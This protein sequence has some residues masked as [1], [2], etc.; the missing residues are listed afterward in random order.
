MEKFV[1]IF[2]AIIGC[3]CSFLCPLFLG[4]DD[5]PAI[6]DTSRVQLVVML[7]SCT[8]AAGAYLAGYAC[9]PRDTE[10][11]GLRDALLLSICWMVFVACDP[12]PNTVGLVLLSEAV[13]MLLEMARPISQ[14]YIMLFCFYGAYIPVMTDVLRDGWDCRYLTQ[15]LLLTQPMI[16]HSLSCKMSQLLEGKRKRKRKRE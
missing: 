1:A 7:V 9:R 13:Y 10:G 3:T 16:I 6:G 5:W 11:T 14:I 4:R 15:P 2:W 12:S 8:A